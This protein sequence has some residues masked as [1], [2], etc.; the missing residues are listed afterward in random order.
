MNARTQ[1]GI[2]L[3]LA[4]FVMVVLSAMV[5]YLLRISILANFAET[6]DVMSTRAYFSARAGVEWSAYQV[7]RPGSS[8]LQNCPPNQTKVFDGFNVALTCQ[9]RDYSEN[10][11]TEN[12]A[13][14]QIV[15]T[16]SRGSPGE[17]AYVERQLEVSI[18]RCINEDN[19]ECN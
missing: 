13:I 10:S 19:L 7:I 5:G 18:S 15:A 9:R 16:A 12:L 1:T 2:S 17:Q 11:G 14:Y 8:V 6:Q 3:P 4:I